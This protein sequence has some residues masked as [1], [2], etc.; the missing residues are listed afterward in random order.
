MRKRASAGHYPAGE[1]AGGGGGGETRGGEA[2]GFALE[3][4]GSRAQQEEER[5][6]KLQW[7]ASMLGP[8]SDRTALGFARNHGGLL[9]DSG[10]PGTRSNP[11]GCV[12]STGTNLPVWFIPHFMHLL[13]FDSSGKFRP[14]PWAMA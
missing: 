6:V 2:G 8:A 14:S 3:C 4:G 11:G 1:P 12:L 10:R 9:L 13:T 7:Q 5:Y